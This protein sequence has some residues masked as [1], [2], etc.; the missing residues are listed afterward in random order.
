M[1]G[2]IEGKEEVGK[3]KE[4]ERKKAR[5]GEEMKQEKQEGT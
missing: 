2:E 1:K 5:E 3:G 4:N